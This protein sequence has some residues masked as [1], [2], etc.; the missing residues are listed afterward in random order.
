MIARL[1]DELGPEHVGP[2]SDRTR[3]WGNG[4]VLGLRNGRWQPEGEN[5]AASRRTRSQSLA[6]ETARSEAA[7][8]AKRVRALT[9]ELEVNKSRT[10]ELIQ[11]SGAA[12]L[13]D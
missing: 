6:S 5:K 7:R 12:P 13:L 9:T 3:N 4:F 10:A 8:L 2:G 1:V 11:A